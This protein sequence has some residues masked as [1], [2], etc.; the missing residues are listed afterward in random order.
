MLAPFDNS[1]IEVIIPEIFK[2]DEV[3]KI[4]EAAC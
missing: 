2:R 1:C 4:N 3:Q